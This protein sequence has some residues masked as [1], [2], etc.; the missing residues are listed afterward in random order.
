MIRFKG[1]EIAEICLINRAFF[2]LEVL[3][4][5]NCGFE[6]AIFLKFGSIHHPYGKRKCCSRRQREAMGFQSTFG[7]KSKGY[8]F[9][10]IHAPVP[11]ATGLSGGIRFL[12]YHRRHKICYPQSLE[13]CSIG[14]KDVSYECRRPLAYPKCLLSYWKSTWSCPV[15]LFIALQIRRT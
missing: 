12:P 11:D 2:I 3:L 7:W 10:E 5:D 13:P 8:G 4:I 14:D 6:M 9:E 1:I 15:L